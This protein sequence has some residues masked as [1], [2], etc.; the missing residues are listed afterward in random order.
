MA[1]LDDAVTNLRAVHRP[2]TGRGREARLGHV[3]DHLEGTARQFAQL[4]AA[5]ED[6]ETGSP[7]TSTRR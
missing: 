4:G 7:G 5:A 3:S 1:T 6:G 2:L